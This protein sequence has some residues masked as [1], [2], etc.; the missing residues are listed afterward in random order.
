MAERSPSLQDQFLNASRRAKTPL[1]VYLMKGVKLQGIITWFDNFSILLRR[2]GATQ[3]IYK[4][5]ISTIQ[6]H[7][8]VP[9]F[10]PTSPEATTRPQLQDVFL[11]AALDQREPMTVFLMNG[12]ML[13]GLV[14]GF[15]QFVVVLERAPYVQ[16]VYKHAMSTLQPANGLDLQG[17]DEQG[18]DA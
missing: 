10:A 4:H 3:L 12:V 11:S 8:A 6:P 7:E 17:E 5:S 14:T 1:T 13:Q 2:E 15:D 18:A 16:L 9:L